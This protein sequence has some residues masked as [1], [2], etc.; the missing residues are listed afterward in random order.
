MKIDFY[1]H[2][3]VFKSVTEGCA[4]IVIPTFCRKLFKVSATLSAKLLLHFE[5]ALP[6][7]ELYSAK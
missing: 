3:L 5:Q 2:T 7:L 4:N 6:L 1:L